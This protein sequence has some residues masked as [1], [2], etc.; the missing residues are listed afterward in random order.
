MRSDIKLVYRAKAAWYN[1]YKFEGYLSDDYFINHYLGITKKQWER[2]GQSGKLKVSPATHALL[3]SLRDLPTGSPHF[4]A[5]F[6]MVELKHGK[7]SAV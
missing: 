4:H 5:M 2:Y 7:R 6:I 3:L 1:F